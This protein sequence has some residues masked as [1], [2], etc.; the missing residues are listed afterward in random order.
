MLVYRGRLGRTRRLSFLGRVRRVPLRG[1]HSDGCARRRAHGC[2]RRTCLGVR[3]PLSRRGLLSGTSKRGGRQSPAIRSR[4]SDLRLA[5]EQRPGRSRG[6]DLRYRHFGP[7]RQRGRHGFRH[8]RRLGRGASSFFRR[9]RK[10]RTGRLF[11]RHDRCR[12]VRRERLHLR[13]LGR[14]PGEG[15][16]LHRKR[17]GLHWQASAG[18]R[19]GR[20]HRVEPRCRRRSC[21]RQRRRFRLFRVAARWGCGQGGRIYPRRP[22]RDVKWGSRACRQC[23]VDPLAHTAARARGRVADRRGGDRERLRS[24]RCRS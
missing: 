2:G 21:M 17:V 11:G 9:H 22:P 3:W 24:G 5:S 23:W 4:I 16:R 13:P 6:G 7:D 19:F 1:G 18:R 8:Q 20:A 14:C 15:E 12:E 10:E